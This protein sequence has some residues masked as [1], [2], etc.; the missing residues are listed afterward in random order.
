M[1]IKLQQDQEQLKTIEPQ[2]A[3]CSTEV[4]VCDIT[5]VDFDIDNFSV[6]INIRNGVTGSLGDHATLKLVDQEDKRTR[7]YCPKLLPRFPKF[8]SPFLALTVLALPTPKRGER[9]YRVLC[10][11]RC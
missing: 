1:R 9:Q 11:G 8:G 3:R 5:D 6:S 2:E 4:I 10:D 7:I